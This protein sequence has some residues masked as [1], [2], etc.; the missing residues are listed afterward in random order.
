MKIK[1]E[2]WTR[3]IPCKLFG[4]LKCGLPVMEDGTRKRSLHAVDIRRV[5]SK[6]AGGT[7]SWD[8]RS[9]TRYPVSRPMFI[10]ILKQH[11]KP[12]QCQ[13]KFTTDDRIWSSRVALENCSCQSIDHSFL[14]IL[15]FPQ[16]TWSWNLACLRVSS[17]RAN[18]SRNIRAQNSRFEAL[19]IFFT[20]R[21]PHRHF[22]KQLANAQH[23][24]S[25]NL[26]FMHLIFIS[27]LPDTPQLS[28]GGITFWQK[29]LIEQ[30]PRL[31]PIHERTVF[32]KHHDNSNRSTTA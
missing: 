20:F 8:N 26:T 4:L 6:Q 27:L 29:P 1:A 32:Q 18:A 5:T 28:S 25:R 23:T 14:P 17:L 10:W 15:Q 19:Q 24:C 30:A 9:Q 3:W 16:C 12:V 21:R 11:K 7:W 2:G 22:N 13:A 31:F